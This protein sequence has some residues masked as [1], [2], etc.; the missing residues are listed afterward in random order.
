MKNNTTP[1]KAR[2]A[3]LLPALAALAFVVSMGNTRAAVT[4]NSSVTFSSGLYTYSYSVTNFG[5]AFDIASID[6]PIAAGA[7]IGNLSA[8]SGFGIISD[9]APVSLVSLFEDSE[10][11]TSAM[12]A[13]DSTVGTFTYESST[14]PLFVTFSALDVNGDTYTG[15]TQSAVPEPSSLLFL[16]SAVLPVLA[17]RSRRHHR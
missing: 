9:G 5:T 3:P 14:A 15:T 7:V 12:F 8:P 13:P 10:I 11:S 16:A 17:S 4:V 1:I 2:F 6:I